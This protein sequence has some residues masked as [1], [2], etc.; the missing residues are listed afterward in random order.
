MDAL[1]E[2]MQRYP[3]LFR[4]EGPVIPSGLLPGWA[5]LVEQLLA[6]IDGLLTDAQAQRFEVGQIKEKFGTL[7]FYWKLQESGQASDD[8]RLLRV[9]MMALVR[10]A[11][12]HSATVCERCGAPGT[13]GENMGWYRVRCESC[14]DNA[15][16]S[17][18]RATHREP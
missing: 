3:R 17:G 9:R 2:L 5:G 1:P 10:E 7:R 14:G 18:T 11:E 12:R 16:G 8:E 13:L 4:G 6:D 15:R